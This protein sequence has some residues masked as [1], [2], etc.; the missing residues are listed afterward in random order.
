MELRTVEFSPDEKQ[1]T[2]GFQRTPDCWTTRM[3]S[4]LQTSSDSNM[5]SKSDA[6][7]TSLSSREGNESSAYELIQYSLAILK[8]VYI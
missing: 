7:C 2:G 8:P 4:C 5:L 3:A 6:E 1:D